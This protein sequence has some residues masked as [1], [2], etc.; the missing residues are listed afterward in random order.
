MRSEKHD[1]L[2][3]SLGIDINLIGH[4]FC[5]GFINVDMRL[6]VFEY[7]PE[8]NNENYLRKSFRFVVVDLSKAKSYPQNFVCILPIN[9]GVGDGKSDSAFVRVFKDKSLEQAKALLKAAWEREDDSEIKA[10]IEKRLLLL[11]P[12]GANKVK[13][14]GCGK[15]FQPKRL[16]KY[17][18]KFC[19]ECMK[20]KFG[21]QT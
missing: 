21:N 15:L 9:L 18:N 16:K 20:K 11:E 19:E 14:C 12:K 1:D 13:C 10:E 5:S 4:H 2:K 3:Q 7:Y 17:K 8:S 6:Q